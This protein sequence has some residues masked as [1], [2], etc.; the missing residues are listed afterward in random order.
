MKYV[1]LDLVKEV[2]KKSGRPNPPEELKVVNLLLDVNNA[3]R[4]QRELDKIPAPRTDPVG[5][6]MRKKRRQGW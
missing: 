1:S 6:K 4:V 3:K 5:A 2:A